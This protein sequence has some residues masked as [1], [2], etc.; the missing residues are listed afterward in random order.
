MSVPPFFGWLL[1]GDGPAVVVGAHAAM[2]VARI[3]VAADRARF[4]RDPSPCASG[5]LA[6]RFSRRCAA[7]RLLPRIGAGSPPEPRCEPFARRDED[8]FAGPGLE[9]S[10]VELN[11]Q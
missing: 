2:T 3:R 8:P 10:G 5:T 9:W 4:I 1:V 7:S 11:D 6:P